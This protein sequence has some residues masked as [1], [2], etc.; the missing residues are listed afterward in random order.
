MPAIEPPITS[1]S[2]FPSSP[3]WYAFSPTSSPFTYSF[4][5]WGP[6]L[7]A[8]WFHP[9]RS[10]TLHDLIVWLPSSPSS[11]T[12]T[13]ESTSQMV[14]PS[15]YPQPSLESIAWR[16]P[17]SVLNQNWIVPSDSSKASS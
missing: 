1:G 16:P 10:T 3:P 5:P 9:R 2:R 4:I 15:P 11:L 6:K 17:L 7:N 12:S 8:R 13:R 14:R